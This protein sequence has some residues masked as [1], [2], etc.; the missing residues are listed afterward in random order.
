MHKSGIVNRQT[1]VRSFILVVILDPSAKGYVIQQQPQ[2]C[3][4]P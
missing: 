1:W 2:N 4:G 3:H